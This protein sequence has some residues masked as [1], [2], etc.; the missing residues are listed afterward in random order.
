MQ[1]PG[2]PSPSPAS[3]NDNERAA[4]V[5]QHQDGSNQSRPG[6]GPMM[7]EHQLTCRHCGAQFTTGHRRTYCTKKCRWAANVQKAK[8]KR[9]GSLRWADGIPATHK[10]FLCVVCGKPFK[11][12]RA[13]RAKCC[14]RECGLAFSG[15][16]AGVVKSGGRISVSVL[17]KRCAQCNR[18]HARMS[19]YCSVECKPS[20][21][22][23]I[24]ACECKA[25]GTQF[26][27][28]AQ[29]TTRYFCSALC[30]ATAH[31]RS[32][33]PG[34]KRRRALER[35]SLIAERVDP[36]RVFDRDAW[37]CG[38]CG[39]ATPKD[40]RGTYHPRAPE[41]DHIIPV[42]LG[43]AH[44]YSNTQCL[45]RSCNAKKGAKIGGQLHLFPTG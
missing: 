21:Y 16:K 28:A 29:G 6:K 20:A 7:A 11:P 39:K 14:G 36:T 13:A 18:Y 1:Q 38:S 17:R 43:G 19:L 3:G 45:C 35:G 22:Q 26:D 12:K 31:R 37:K 40:K 25:C 23:P 4:K 30:Q 9:G 44:T 2:R 5:Y 33:R 27:R 34:K 42:S 41:L 10:T 15:F 32:K 8:L 24:I